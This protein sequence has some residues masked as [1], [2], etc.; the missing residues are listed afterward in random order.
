MLRRIVLLARRMVLCLLLSSSFT[1]SISAQQPGN[2]QIALPDPAASAGRLVRD[3]KWGPVID[4]ITT[5]WSDSA[6][7]V[8]DPVGI[9]SL[10]LSSQKIAAELEAYRRQAF[11]I[12]QRYTIH[13]YEILC[14]QRGPGNLGHGSV[15]SCA[16]H[17]ADGN[18]RQVEVAQAA[19]ADRLNQISALEKAHAEAV[20]REGESKAMIARINA[21]TTTE[22][23]TIERLVAKHAGRLLLAGFGYHK[24]E[25]PWV[26][27]GTR[28][29]G[30]AGLDGAPQAPV[31]GQCHMFIAWRNLSDDNI[32]IHALKIQW[33]DKAGKVIRDDRKS[34]FSGLLAPNRVY[35]TTHHPEAVLFP[36][37]CDRLGA[38][39]L[40][41]LECTVNGQRDNDC[42]RRVT[43]P[44]AE[45]FR[46]L[47]PTLLPPA[48][49]LSVAQT[50][51]IQRVLGR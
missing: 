15:A 46:V 8:V 11:K 42:I 40:I 7:W 5:G 34:G 28:Y 36:G 33:L 43:V 3:P 30:L 2:P 37:V 31:E 45:D 19:E 23:A 41:G 1:T 22:R 25:G 17:Y 27:A 4:G 29:T 47:S 51:L 16:A 9:D 49:T 39:L 18:R 12:P 50:G 21:W 44:P 20:Q 35:R 24:P 6:G 14:R 48:F 38:I 10:K 26:R 13:D 32:E